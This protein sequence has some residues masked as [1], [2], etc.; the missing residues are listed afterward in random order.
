MNRIPRNG[1][2]LQRIL[3]LNYVKMFRGDI[4]VMEKMHLEQ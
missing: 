2:L 1:R 3:F 4:A